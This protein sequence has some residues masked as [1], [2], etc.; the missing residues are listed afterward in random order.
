MHPEEKL[1][2]LGITLPPPAPPGGNY[3]PYVITGN[4]L[5]RHPTLRIAFSHGGGT[6]A[7][8]LPRL[9][10]GAKSFPALREQVRVSPSQQA[11][12]LYFDTL[13]YDE[14]MLRHLVATFGASARPFAPRG[15]AS[16]VSISTKRMSIL[17]ASAH[18][19]S[20]Y[21]NSAALVW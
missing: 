8:L 1:A 9:E 6:L 13:V 17:G 4:L 14:P 12:K 21:S 3:E 19:W 11:R 2:Q 15:P 5:L 18:V 10:E 7:S 16:G 20:L